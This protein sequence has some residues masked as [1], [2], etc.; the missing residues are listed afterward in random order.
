MESHSH[1]LCQSGIHLAPVANTSHPEGLTQEGTLR[2]QCQALHLHPSDSARH[3][4]RKI[5]LFGDRSVLGNHEAR[6]R[7]LSSGGLCCKVERAS[8]SAS[9]RLQTSMFSVGLVFTI[10]DHSEYHA[11][12]PVADF[13]AGWQP[14]AL[15]VFLS[16]VSIKSNASVD[17]VLIKG[18]F[19]ERFCKHG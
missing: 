9:E 10:A 19:I 12:L 6:L 2:P 14:N 15:L 11:H 1:S 13:H 4:K 3:S 17:C 16:D 5:E 7:A 8:P 18:P